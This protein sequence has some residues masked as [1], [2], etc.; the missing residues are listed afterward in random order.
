M[1][2][3]WL[4]FIVTSTTHLGSTVIN[5]DAIVFETA[6]RCV[7]NVP[8]VQEQLKG[9]YDTISVQCVEEK[10]HPKNKTDE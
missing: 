1:I 4:L 3:V 8:L 5:A 7:K 10:L 9:K 6:D 2:S